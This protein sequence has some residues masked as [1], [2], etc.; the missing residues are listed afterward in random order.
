MVEHLEMT[1]SSSA[2]LL[3]HHKKV[4]EDV[5]NMRQNLHMS[6]EQIAERE[7]S[8]DLQGFLQRESV[9]N[10]EA[11]LNNNDDQFHDIPE[12]AKAPAKIVNL[13]AQKVMESNFQVKN[14][15]S[16]SSSFAFTEST[17]LNQNFEESQSQDS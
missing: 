8:T 14:K 17:K 10:S 1:K 4:I 11:V 13:S 3:F 5:Q 16:H 15:E 12:A 7:Q 9:F 2:A 6:I